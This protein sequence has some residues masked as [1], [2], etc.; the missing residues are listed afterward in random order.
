MK[1][2]TKTGDDGTTGLFNG[3]RVPKSSLRVETYGTVDELNSVIGIVIA[4]QVPEEIK[5]DLCKI[6]NLLFVLGSDLATPLESSN[7]QKIRRITNKEIEL[8]ERKIDEYTQN[9]PPLKNFILP[10]GSIVSSYLHL[11]RTVCR[12]TERLL[13]RLSEKEEINKNSMIFLN[14][15]SDYLFTASRYANFLLGFN[16]ILWKNKTKGNL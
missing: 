4:N 3:Q 7:K 5:N 13:V 8:L 6:S 12:R 10:G 15:L 9:I 11:A 1:I 2:Y 16:D 14:R